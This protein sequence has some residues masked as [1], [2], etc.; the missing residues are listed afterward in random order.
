MLSITI[1]KTELF[2]EKTNEFISINETKLQLE[3]SLISV[4]KW[5]SKWKQPF[6]SEKYEKTTEQVLDYIKCMTITQNVDSVVYRAIPSKAFEEITSYIKDP[7]T[8]AWFPKEYGLPKISNRSSQTITYEIIYYWMIT[9]NVPVE[10]EKWHLNQ[11]LTLIKV[12]NVE[13]Q[14]KKKMPKKEAARQ[15]ALLNKQRRAQLNTKG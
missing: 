4:K 1:P 5:E 10:F 15:R 12:I 13:N 11:L 9:F 2:D 6:L 3:H 7:M 14:S 8:A